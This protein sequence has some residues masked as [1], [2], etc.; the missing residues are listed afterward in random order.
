L[1]NALDSYQAALEIYE[2]LKNLSGQAD[3]LGAIGNVYLKQDELD[4]AHKSFL[5]A[6]GILKKMDY[7]MG[8][9]SILAN[10]G[11]LNLKQRKKVEALNL[12][13]QSYDTYLKIGAKGEAQR[14]VEEKIMKL[15]EGHTDFL[16]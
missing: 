4:E 10:M 2:G 7:P 15:S 12:Y 6:L 5:T 3:I 8:R 16:E 11:D 1:D 9:A 13:V 14:R